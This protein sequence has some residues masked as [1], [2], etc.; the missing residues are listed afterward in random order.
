MKHHFFNESKSLTDSRAILYDGTQCHRSLNAYLG[1]ANSL[2]RMKELIDTG[3][4]A[5]PQPFS[6]A[7]RAPLAG[8]QLVYTAHGPVHADGRIETGSIEAQ[9][10]LTL[11]NLQRAMQAAQGGLDDVTQVLVYLTDIADMP[12]VDAVYREFFPTSFPNRSSAAVSALAVPGMKIE[13]VVHAVVHPAIHSA[14]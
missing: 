6:W 8:A 9:T 1:T 11:Q 10:R 5:L 14:S 2:A 4:P 7:V 12:K 13:I 3:L